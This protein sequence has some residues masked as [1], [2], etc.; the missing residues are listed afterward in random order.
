[1]PTHELG[2]TAVFGRAYLWGESSIRCNAGVE[3]VWFVD[4]WELGQHCLLVL[5]ALTGLAVL[6]WKRGL[7][8]MALSFAGLVAVDL[9]RTVEADGSGWPQVALP[10]FWA[11]AAWALVL[12]AVAIAVRR[13]RCAL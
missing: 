11:F 7:D 3:I 4:R 8:L 13:R 6:A 9:R 2:H 10:A 1:M 5:S 12:G